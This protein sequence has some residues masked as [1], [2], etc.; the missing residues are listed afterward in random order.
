ML[1][2]GH[3]KNGIVVFDE[4]VPLPEGTLVS[5]AIAAPASIAA[6]D[7][8]FARGGARIQQSPCDEL[9]VM[10]VDEGVSSIDPLQIRRLLEE[11]GF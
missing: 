1:L 8:S 2:F 7:D 9:P 5:V 4:P 3:I 11:E 6:P 10:V